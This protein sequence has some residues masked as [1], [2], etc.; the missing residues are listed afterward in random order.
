MKSVLSGLTFLRDHCGMQYMLDTDLVQGAFP[1]QQQV[2]N[3]QADPLLLRD[4]MCLESLATSANSV[5]AF[6][7]TMAACIAYGGVRFA[8]TQ[9]SRPLRLVQ[10]G[11]MLWCSQ[12]K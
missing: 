5:V 11:L 6:I 9:R 4:L 3:K 7:A 12:G 1:S 10:G 8:H 2:S